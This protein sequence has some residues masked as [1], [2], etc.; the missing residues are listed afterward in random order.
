LPRIELVESA[1]LLLFRDSPFTAQSIVA[2]A[3]EHQYQDL[4]SFCVYVKPYCFP[5]RAIFSYLDFV[6]F[7]TRLGKINQFLGIVQWA[8]SCSLL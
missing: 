5:M 4:F 6:F 3:I 1:N 8:N 2:T 7:C